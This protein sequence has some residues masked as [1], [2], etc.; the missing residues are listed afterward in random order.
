MTSSTTVLGETPF[1]KK[2]YPGDKV[3]GEGM[4]GTVL[5]YYSKETKTPVAVKTLVLDNIAS[6]RRTMLLSEVEIYLRISHHNVV[7]LIEVFEQPDKI[8]LIM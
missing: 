6:S 8:H 7:K 4:S 5:L 1:E 3:L 2:Y